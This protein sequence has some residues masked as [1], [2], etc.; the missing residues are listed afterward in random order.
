MI[1]GLRFRPK[2]IPTLAALGLIALT[3]Y[4]G[5]WQLERA[6]TKQALQARF[7]Q[8]QKDPP[9]AL[10]DRITAPESYEFLRVE[11]RGTYVP[12]HE[13][14][15]DNKI[16]QGVA[17]YHVLT[18][19]RLSGSDAHVLVNRGWIPA[20]L[21]RDVLPEVPTPP[22]EQRVE[23]IATAAKG[24]Y[25][26]LSER[27]RDGKVWQNLSLPLYAQAAPFR[28][29]PIVVLD[30]TPSRNGLV[31]IHEQPD[32][33]VTMHLGYAFQWYSLAVALAVIYLALNLK[34]VKRI[35]PPS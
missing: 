4:L 27:N 1:A 25:L 24:R 6:H 18:P 19:L 31:R 22:G 26:E 5:H 23:G 28:V 11:V 33:G 35:D 16:H 21:R 30:Q 9:I 17:G 12:A 34:R 8:L 14:Y 3:S 20:G 2:L 32:T 10:P 13:L 29:L 7:E 15:L